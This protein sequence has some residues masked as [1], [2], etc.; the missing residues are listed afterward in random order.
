MQEGNK[1]RMVKCCFDKTILRATR[2]PL[3]VV[4]STRCMATI[5]LYL[6]FI[7]QV[8]VLITNIHL[9]IVLFTIPGFTASD[10]S[11]VSINFS[12]INICSNV[13]LE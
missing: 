12:L 3:S 5:A 8:L 1:E 13:I 4:I 10:N 2:T 7:R 9:A 6:I 11:C